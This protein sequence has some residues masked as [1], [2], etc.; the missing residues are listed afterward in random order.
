ML[1]L[2]ITIF[3]LFLLIL[4]CITTLFIVLFI[5][6][7]NKYNK[8]KRELKQAF[9]RIFFLEN[10]LYRR[11]VAPPV[12]QPDT[13]NVVTTPAT[14]PCN[15][16]TYASAP[17]T[18]PISSQTPHDATVYSNTPVQSQAVYSTTPPTQSKNIASKQSFSTITI[19]LILGAF[20]LNIAGLIFATNTWDS[21]PQ[22]G[23]I[24]TLFSF[25]LIFFMLSIVANFKLNLD[26]TAMVFHTIG[27]F[28]LPITVIAG[29]FLSVFGSWLNITGDG[30]YLFMAISTFLL[31][32]STFIGGKL[33]KSRFLVHITLASLS[34]TLFFIIYQFTQDINIASIAIGIYSFVLIILP[35]I[36][37]KDENGYIGIILSELTLFSVYNTII[38]SLF[39]LMGAD[40]GYISMAATAI[41]AICYL[42]SAA[43]TKQH[44]G[45]TIAFIIFLT[46]SMY[47]L[48]SPTDITDLSIWVVC[49]ISIPMILAAI[50]F[51]T[52]R[53]TDILAIAS[54]V[55]TIIGT[56]FLLIFALFSGPT[57]ESFIVNMILLIELILLIYFKRHDKM[58]VRLKRILPILLIITTSI[59]VN[60]AEIEWDIDATLILSIALILYQ[61]IYIL[62]PKLNIRTIASDIT[63]L[64]TITFLSLVNSDN[65]GYTEFYL[66]FIIMLLLLCISLISFIKARTAIKITSLSIFT[67]ILL[68]TV[69][70]ILYYDIT[71]SFFIVAAGLIMSVIAILLFYSHQ[72]RLVA[73]VYS[74]MSRFALF[75]LAIML[76][77]EIEVI[78]PILVLAIIISLFHSYKMNSSKNIIIASLI[79]ILGLPIIPTKFID[80]ITFS[81]YILFMLL[82]A[83]IITLI[84][85]LI[86][87]KNNIFYRAYEV[88]GRYSFYTLLTILLIIADSNI[89]SFIISPLALIY[90]GILFY[91]KGKRLHLIA[92]TA[93]YS[94]LFISTI[95]YTFDIDL[96][97]YANAI[98]M[99][100]AGFMLIYILAS[101]F[102]PSKPLYD[103]DYNSSNI[104][105]FPFIRAA[106]SVVLFM[107]TLNE[108]CGWLGYVIALLGIF[109]I[110]RPK[111]PTVFRYF[112][113]SINTLIGL[114]A[115]GHG[116][117]LQTLVHIPDLISTELVLILC[118]AFPVILIYIW[119]HHTPK[120]VLARNA[121]KSLTYIT[122]AIT[123]LS[124]MILLADIHEVFD[125]LFITITAIIILVVSFILRHQPWFV[126]SLVTTIIC[127]I[128]MSGRY[129]ESPIWWV[130]MLCCGILLITLGVANELK[131][132]K[133][134]VTENKKWLNSDWK[135]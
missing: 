16:T 60:Y 35:N 70:N 73:T 72:M 118:V 33:Y 119:S 129:W 122:I 101:K 58:S 105:I 56:M 79:F 91:S 37:K 48:I 113:Y 85:T 64:T 53:L 23:K 51:F 82:G 100:Y 103:K 128:F 69:L 57:L 76:Y 88:T 40:I 42:T 112:I 30:R 11:N 31:M 67:F 17:I 4:L 94:L 38:L 61:L 108:Y 80:P 27:S 32:I 87:L 22:F 125:A 36:I 116:L 84:A 46:I 14:A 47:S 49:V 106:M 66:W 115:I 7:V 2:I 89:I 78:T 81:E 123:S 1:D 111:Q 124:Y 104:D 99:V 21:L 15:S 110:L 24:A 20:F 34:A 8:T 97:D 28:F 29:G 65:L 135:L 19:I 18:S 54:F 131:K 92:P 44:A 77:A 59:G 41:F 93:I 5:I 45:N 12:N 50:G 134:P 130:L 90:I 6:Y 114:I 74:A 25:S 26:K 52:Q 62:V 55:L 10:E 109:S 3:V 63:F 43:T 107:M 9:S 95:R 71:S 86:S 133:E 127:M 13:V 98:P 120:T 121:Y 39:P 102:I 68:L 126:M 96:A 132:Q 75:I 83:F 117:A